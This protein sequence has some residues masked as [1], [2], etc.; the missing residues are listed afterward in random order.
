MSNRVIPREKLE[1]PPE[2]PNSIIQ[3]AKPQ[4]AAE[5]G[6][7]QLLQ[8]LGLPPLEMLNSSKIQATLDS[9][10]CDRELKSKEGLRGLNQSIDSL[11]IENLSISASTNNLI[12]DG[13]LEDTEF[14]NIELSNARLRSR[15]TNLEA[16]IGEIGS[17]MAS[18]DMKK[19]SLASAKRDDF[20]KNW[21]S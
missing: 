5:S 16:E 10:I 19:L 20:L 9:V 15:T 21:A 3:E 7:H 4:S 1:A 18:L 12:F 6:H 8:S 11:L 17:D 13:L 14:N 2:N